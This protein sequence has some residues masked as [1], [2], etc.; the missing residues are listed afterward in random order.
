MEILF[1]LPVFHAGL[2]VTC[3]RGL[4]W[5]HIAPSVRLRAI[6]SRTRMFHRELT[7]VS[8][9]HYAGVDEIPE[10]VLQ[11]EHDSDCRTREGLARELKRVYGDDWETG[12]ITVLW[13][14]AG[15]VN[16]KPPRG[17]QEADHVI[18]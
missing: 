16:H 8:S 12:G 7:V 2:N 14:W 3:R 5:Y 18:E 9:D 11:F 4:K 17:P 15:D 13:L 6:S 1:E 10:F